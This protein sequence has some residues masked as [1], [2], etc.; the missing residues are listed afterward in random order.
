MKIKLAVF[1]SPILHSLSPI[2]FNKFF[3]ISKD[4]GEYVRIHEDNPEMAVQ[5]M[6]DMELTAASITSPL[7]KSIIEHLDEISH[8]AKQIGAV[9]TI[10]K[11]GKLLTG[12]NTDWI[13]VKNLIKRY[14]NEE[15]VTSKFTSALVIGAGGASHAVIYALKDLGIEPTIVNRTLNRAKELAKKYECSHIPIKKLPKEIQKHRLVIST[16]PD[17]S[18]VLK[19]LALTSDHVLFDANYKNPGN[20]LSQLKQKP[21][22]I[23]GKQ[24][25]LEQALYAFELILSKKAPCINNLILNKKDLVERIQHGTIDIDGDD[26]ELIQNIRQKLCPLILGTIKNEEYAQLRKVHFWVGRPGPSLNFSE[27]DMYLNPMRKNPSPLKF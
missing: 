6:K 9:N 14:E 20:L 4:D 8:D 26:T 19:Y 15:G 23:T 13:G 25:L 22:L 5:T 1:G 17:T 12:H 21:R 27:M 2:I 16:I 11:K 10:I 3:S 7:K 24:W 18:E